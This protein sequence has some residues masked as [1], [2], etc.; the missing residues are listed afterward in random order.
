MSLFLILLAQAS[1]AVA[2]VPA[3]PTPFTNKE[4][5]KIICKTV[6]GTGSRLD[7]QRLCMPKR[8]W[9]RMWD[10]SKETMGGLQDHQYK[11]DPMSGR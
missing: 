7:T 4:D 8:E 2:P 11:R 10:N 9:Q 1:T 5:S 3:A 6:L